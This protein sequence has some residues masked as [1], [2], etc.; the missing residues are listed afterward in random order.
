MMLATVAF[1]VVW[2][3]LQ[4]ESQRLVMEQQQR[5]QKE[6]DLE[7]LRA[8]GESLQAQLD[9]A[10]QENKKNQA[11][12]DE[13]K[14]QQQALEQQIQ[15]QLQQPQPGPSL[16]AL[17]LSP[18]TGP[19]GGPGKKP[20]SISPKTRTVQLNLD[21]GAEDDYDSY[22]ASLHDISVGQRFIN[23]WTDLKSI[24][25][26]GSKYIRLAVPAR[27]LTPGIY[28]VQI[29]G[30]SSGQAEPLPEYSFTITR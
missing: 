29:E 19:R 20:Y 30:V 4:A 21:V 3:R 6:R 23:R 2:S 9:Q 8:R 16:L 14:Q 22:N 7:T 12:I 17:Y 24:G 15:Q 18:G 11:Q 27:S 13:L 5:E 28:S 25:D 1:L 10:Q 26:R